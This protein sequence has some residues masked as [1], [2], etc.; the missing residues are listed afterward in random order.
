MNETEFNTIRRQEFCSWDLAHVSWA[1]GTPSLTYWSSYAFEEET[2]Q[3]AYVYLIEDGLDPTHT[4]RR[5]SAKTDSRD[6]QV[7][8]GV[9]WDAEPT[10]W[11]VLCAIG[12]Q[13]QDRRC[14][15]YLDVS[16]ILCSIK[17]CRSYIWGL[18]E[19]QFDCFESH[20]CH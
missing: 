9:L 1:P 3:D 7:C 19:I 15:G 5:D 18:K 10:N 14:Y 17:G 6:D 20:V 13:H 2:S 4:I 16:W 12:S 11:L 8:Q